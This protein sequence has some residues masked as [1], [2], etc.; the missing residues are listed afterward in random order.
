MT[1]T[2]IKYFLYDYLFS[3]VCTCNSSFINIGRD[4]SSGVKEMLKYMQRPIG[5]YVSTNL[6]EEDKIQIITLI[7]TCD[8]RIIRS[9]QLN[10][11]SAPTQESFNRGI[12]VETSIVNV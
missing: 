4:G 8:D 7:A 9:A 3:F 12:P 6:S 10:I 11:S 5:L 1:S 2:L